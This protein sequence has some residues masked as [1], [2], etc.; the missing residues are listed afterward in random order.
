METNN[1]EELLKHLS[2]LHYESH[3]YFQFI[4]NIMLHFQHDL[5]KL[6]DTDMVTKALKE[7][8]NGKNVLN[9][10]EKL[11]NITNKR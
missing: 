2:K 9:R 3:T 6:K 1:N 7:I 11:L 10:F 4:L 5:E 8:T